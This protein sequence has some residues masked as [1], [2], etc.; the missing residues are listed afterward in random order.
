M[1]ASLVSRECGGTLTLV[2]ESG[3]L[4]RFLE[5]PLTVPLRGVPVRGSYSCVIWRTVRRN[6]PGIARRSPGLCAAGAW[7]YYPLPGL[8]AWTACQTH[9][10]VAGMSMCRT[11]RW[12]TASMT[13][14]C[15]AG[16]APIVPA[17]PMPL[18]PRGL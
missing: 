3:V 10:G 7:P 9:W 4:P 8:A 12:A 6:D 1:T 5:N 13:A 15:T 16:V 14:F 11:P 17:S 18:A 2:N